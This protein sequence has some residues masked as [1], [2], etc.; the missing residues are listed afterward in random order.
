MFQERGN[1]FRRNFTPYPNTRVSRLH[2]DTRKWN[3]EIISFFSVRFT[4]RKG[5]LSTSRK[6]K[7]FSVSAGAGYDVHYFA[8][9]TPSSEVSR[10]P[11]GWRGGAGLVTENRT[12]TDKKKIMPRVSGNFAGSFIKFSTRTVAERHATAHGWRFF[13]RPSSLVFHRSSVINYRRPASSGLETF[14]LFLAEEKR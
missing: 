4:D 14:K 8:F 13:R 5:S 11:T 3:H 12:T 7:K 1:V 10:L 9:Q 6:P 2:Q